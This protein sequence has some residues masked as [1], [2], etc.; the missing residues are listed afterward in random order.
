[1][2]YDELEIKDSEEI[3]TAEEIE[4]AEPAPAA[5][6]MEEVPAEFEAIDE[7]EAEVTEDIEEAEEPAEE[8]EEAED[9]LVAALGG[10]RDAIAKADSRIF[11]L[12]GQI[13]AIIEREAARNKKLSGFFAPIPDG[14]TEADS[15]PLPRIERK[16]IY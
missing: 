1:M 14:K 11:A 9:G 16:Y 7:T 4:A 15:D 13:A 12:E 3:L 8:A 5:E 2:P 6:A 10:L